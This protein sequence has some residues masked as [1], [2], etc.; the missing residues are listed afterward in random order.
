MLAQQDPSY[1]RDGSMIIGLGKFKMEIN[2]KK[3]TEKMKKEM[4]KFGDKSGI[5]FD[6]DKNESKTSSSAAATHHR[7]STKRRED[8]DKPKQK[9]SIFDI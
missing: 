6:I 7:F 1:Q 9:E 5:G 3:E 2:I 4:R 8:E